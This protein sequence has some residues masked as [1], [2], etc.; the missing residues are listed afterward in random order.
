MRFRLQLVAE[1]REELMALLS[2]VY[3]DM[4]TNEPDPEDEG[5]IPSDTSKPRAGRWYWGDS[6]WEDTTQPQD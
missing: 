6:E 4:L 3:A 1:T 5:R 2:G